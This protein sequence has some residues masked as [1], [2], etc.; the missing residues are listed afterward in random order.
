MKLTA[1]QKIFCDEYII[2]LNATQA[3]IKAGYSKKTASSR[4][5]DKTSHPKLYLRTNEAKR[6]LID[7][8]TG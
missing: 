3:A 6:K 1:K 7:S 8:H 2:S 4:K 5:P